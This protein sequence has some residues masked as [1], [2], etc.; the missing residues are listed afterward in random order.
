MPVVGRP[1]QA[2]DPRHRRLPAATIVDILAFAGWGPQIAAGRSAEAR[3]GGEKALAL[4]LQAGLGWADGPSGEPLYDPIEVQNCLAWAATSGGNS[5]WADQAR[6]I[7]RAITE[8]ERRPGHAGRCGEPAPA[9][10]RVFSRRT[11]NL[12]A[13]DPGAKIRLRL[14]LPLRCDYHR[15]VQVRPRVA[16]ALEGAVTVSDGR[17]EVRLDVPRDPIVTIGVDL[18]FVALLPPPNGPTPP[19]G[20]A[21]REAHL[22]PVEGL[23]RVTPTVRDLALR[24]AGTR[25]PQQ[26]VVAFCRF[27]DEHVR[28][29][30]VWYDEVSLSAPGDWVLENGVYDCQL[31]AALLVSLCRANGIPA[32]LVSGHYLHRLAPTNHNWI[33]VWLD[34]RGWTPLDILN[35]ERERP[36]FA[37]GAD[38][39][40]HFR[41]RG[42]YRLVTQTPPLAFTGPMSVRLPPAWLMLHTAGDPGVAITYLDIADASLIYRDTVSVERTD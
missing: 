36:E 14:P 33:D 24:L 29:A 42:D 6:A 5:F 9:R 40:E 22:R 37:I 35:R 39:P 28:F 1:A 23:I 19:L 38:W 11:F 7:D 3:A 27:L 30:F 4:A 26:A 18:E 15:D 8:H 17:L 31:S 32:R 12:G 34:G 20:A 21:D 2:T 16:E 41:R 25:A 10:F 13:F